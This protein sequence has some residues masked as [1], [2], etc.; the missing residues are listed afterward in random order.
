MD[1]I[2]QELQQLRSADK[3]RLWSGCWLYS[4]HTSL[5]LHQYAASVPAIGC[6]CCCLATAKL[7]EI[8]MTSVSACPALLNGN[9]TQANCCLIHLLPGAS[10]AHALWKHKAAI[11]LELAS[12]LPCNPHAIQP[13]IE[14][15]TTAQRY[16]CN[17][18]HGPLDALPGP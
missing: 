13:V 4:T 9:T 1:N 8:A 12:L 6:D 10:A 14:C 3:N 16:I 2:V 7:L 18:R 15:H 17:A 11:I 5:A